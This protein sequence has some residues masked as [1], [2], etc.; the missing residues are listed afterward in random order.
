MLKG[1]ADVTMKTW[2]SGLL[3]VEVAI[4]MEESKFVDDF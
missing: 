3:P 2:T 4:Q 1:G